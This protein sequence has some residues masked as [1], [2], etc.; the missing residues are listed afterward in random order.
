MLFLN[1]L[2]KHSF[3]INL[4]SCCYDKDLN[5][6]FVKLK[7]QS[8]SIILIEVL[9]V[10]FYHIML[11]VIYTHFNYFLPLC[12]T[13]K[14]KQHW[15]IEDTHWIKPIINCIDFSKYTFTADLQF[16]TACDQLHSRIINA[17]LQT[18]FFLNFL[19]CFLY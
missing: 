11:S 5:W 3:I 13:I 4:Y 18:F 2:K 6:L 15:Q 14:L 1:A 12:L 8:I 16:S 17:R 19:T 9:D 7:S 10:V